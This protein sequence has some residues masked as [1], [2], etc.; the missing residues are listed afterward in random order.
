MAVSQTRI[1]ATSEFDMIPVPPRPRAIQLTNINGILAVL[2]SDGRLF[3][4][5]DDNTKIGQPHGPHFRWQEV[6]LPQ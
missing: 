2:M 6:A 1:E 3:K 4:Q 5:V